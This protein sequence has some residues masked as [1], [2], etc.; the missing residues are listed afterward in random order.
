MRIP[1]YLML[2]AALVVTPAQHVDSQTVSPAPGWSYADHADLALAS[3]IVAVGTVREAIRLKGAQAAGAPAG[4]ARFY[5]VTDITALIRGASGLASRVAYLADVP[6][7][8]NGKPPKL[9]KQ[10]VILLARP[11]TGRSGELQLIARDA[12]LPWTAASESTIRAILTEAV[13]P[14]APPR[15]TGIGNAFHVPGTLPGEGETQIFLNTAD[16]RPVSLSVIHRPGQE[17]QWAVAL[18][19]IVDQAAEAPKP[20]T[21]LWY[22]LACS[23]PET[24]PAEALENA[25]PEHTDA[26]RRDYQLVREALGPCQRNRARS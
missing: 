7:Q 19:E 3:P 21:L 17:P 12:Q 10:K 23:L 2:A 1:P 4:H 15:I 26:A 11:V 16:G 14:D 18:S 5:V 9:K 8:P 24:L 22:R 13:Q 6:L 20:D 25:N